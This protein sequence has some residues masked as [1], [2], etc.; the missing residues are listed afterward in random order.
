MK[1][2]SVMFAIFVCFAFFISP[3][4]AE[5]RPGRQMVQTCKADV[6]TYC[7]DVKPGGGR[8]FSCL[9]ANSDKIS[10]PCAQMVNAAREKKKSIDVAIDAVKER[11][12]A[13]VDQFCK[14]VTPG[15]GRILSCLH[16][17]SDRIS[18]PCAQ[19]VNKAEEKVKA[20]SDAIHS[21]KE[22]CRADVEQFCKDVAPGRG[23]MARCL[24]DN[25]ASISEK[26]KNALRE[27][28]QRD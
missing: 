19:V 2:I 5:E 8:I 1:S 12:Q 11:C 13:D 7:Q 9:D 14:D 6:Q 16:A 17:N 23:R 4:N 18:E 22:S 25:R 28:A 21:V 24:E 15:R 20:I 10:E 3:V 26:C 27:A